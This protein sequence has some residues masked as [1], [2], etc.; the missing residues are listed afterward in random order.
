MAG[1]VRVHALLKNTFSSRDFKSVFNLE[2]ELDRSRPR[3]LSDCAE[4]TGKRLVTTVSARGDEG[5]AQL[6]GKPSR[7]AGLLQD[8]AIEDI[9][10]GCPEVD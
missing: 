9:E 2:P 5:R 10:K 7:A 1:R 6:R 3:G 4:A 8:V